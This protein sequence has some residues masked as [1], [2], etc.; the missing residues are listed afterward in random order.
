MTYLSKID[1]LAP[2]RPLPDSGL[3]HSKSDVVNP[4]L[5]SRFAHYLARPM[6]RAGPLL[7]ASAVLGVLALAWWQRDEGHLTAESG[8]G[9]WLGIAGAVFMLMLVGYPLRKRLKSFQRLGRVANWFRLHMII[10]ILGPALVVLHTNFKLG[11][12]NS[13]LALLTMLIVVA[14][15]I[16]GRYIYAKLHKGLYGKQLALRDVHADLLALKRSLS[17]GV[18]ETPVISAELGK[19]LSASAGSPSLLA[20][21]S[22]SLFSGARTRASRHA[23]LREIKAQLAE[24]TPHATR[25]QRRQSLKVAD[26]HLRLFF[27]AAKKAGRLAFF[28]HVFSL[29]HHL[30]F[31]LFVLLLLTVVIHIVAVHL[32]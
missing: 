13:R 6:L 30:H 4:A 31:P 10:G 32:Y 21:F 23:V 11:S 16:A 14:S 22:T 27:A 25:S 29:W 2:P 8:I 15:G 17:E 18:M 24:S 20:S 26:Q 9:Y 12:L 28:D 19:Y 5:L 1:A 3:R 7:F